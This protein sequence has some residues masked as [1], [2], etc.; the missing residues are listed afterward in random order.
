MT[1]TRA[2]TTPAASPQR[3]CA[4]ALPVCVERWLDTLEY[5][6]D[7]TVSI[8]RTVKDFD[9]LDNLERKIPDGCVGMIDQSFGAWF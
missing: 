9:L 6:E 4:V 2:S 3:C 8:F 5:I 7:V 1:G